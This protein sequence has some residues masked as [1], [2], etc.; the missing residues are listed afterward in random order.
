MQPTAV[1]SGP[2]ALKLIEQGQQ[3]D[4]AILDMQMPEMDGFTLA[5]RI[6]KNI[7]KA[8]PLII[9][10]SIK[11]DNTR[12]GD[13]KIS[14]FLSKPIKPSSLYNVLTDIMVAAPHQTE[15]PQKV[16]RIDPDM[17]KRHPLHI[18]LAEDN[19]INQKVAVR[20]F[21]RLGYRADV[22][23]NGLEALQALERQHYDV[24]F[25]DI[26]MP[27]MDGD[28][29]TRRIR[30]DMPPERQPHIIAMTANALEGDREKYLSR[31]MDDYVSKPIRVEALI[32]ALE[33]APRLAEHS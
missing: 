24:V 1:E 22:A 21:E 27:E 31:G 14:A 9:L 20:L 10:T 33:N 16:H 26:Q 30:R 28:E 11:R 7:K 6:G 3:F 25:M 2:Q 8:L 19:P 15:A 5:S 17:G 13:A 29:A 12:S 4:I 32:A 23:G 18:L